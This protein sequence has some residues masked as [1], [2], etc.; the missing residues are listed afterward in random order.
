MA[1][2]HQRMAC[3]DALTYLVAGAEGYLALMAGHAA[4]RH[5]FDETDI[6]PTLDG[7]LHQVENLVVVAALLHH[8]VELDAFEAGAT[9]S[10]DAFEHLVEPITAGQLGETLAFERVEADIEPSHAGFTQRCSQ[11]RQLRAVGGDGQIFQFIARTEPRQQAGQP[12]AHQR[13]ATRHA[14][15]FDAQ[16][17][18]GI[19]HRIELFERE[20]LRTGREDHVFAHAIG[21]AK[22]AAVGYRQPQVG[23]A[24]AEWVDQLGIGH[25]TLQLRDAPVFRLCAKY[26]SGKA[27]LPM[28]YRQRHRVACSR[29]GAML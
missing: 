11:A 18:E 27:T 21:A 22:I 17:D 14:D 6:Q 19:G 1:A 15:A 25:G 10:L 7:E 2:A 23:D 20:D 26:D 24:P 9:R 8:A 12:L 3:L 16:A 5:L 13:F 28:A 4:Q 29:P